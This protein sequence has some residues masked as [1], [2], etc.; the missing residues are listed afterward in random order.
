MPD[1]RSRDTTAR[2]SSG[3]VRVVHLEDD[4]LDLPITVGG[5]R[6]RAVVGPH[7]G[8]RERSLIY[9][10]LPRAARS[11]DLRHPNEAVFY[12]VKGRGEVANPR[13]RQ[14]Y[15][16]REGQM[17]YVKPGQEYALVGPAVFAGG[18]CPPDPALLDNTRAT[19]MPDLVKSDDGIRIF[20]PT[21]DGIHMP[22]IARRSWLVV[23]PH[24]GAQY[25]VM[26]V[27]ELDPGEKNVPHVHALSEDSL[28]ILSGS[29]WAHDLDAGQRLPLRAGC[30]VVVPA[31]IR[32]TIEAGADGLKSVGGPVPPDLDML[33]AMGV[34]TLS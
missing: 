34:K 20:E 32:H 10:D 13:T 30:A 9:L 11:I 31:G 23:S 4:G 25:A 2:A 7:V 8:A 33:R 12:V 29:G 14:M 17:I 21:R 6:A 24:M 15:P 19:P 16:V 27:V 18:P 26:N 28:F 3:S 5:G 22:M 1:P